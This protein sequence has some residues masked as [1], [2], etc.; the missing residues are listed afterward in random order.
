MQHTMTLLTRALE[1]RP[2]PEWTRELG[3]SRNALANAKLRG[4]VSPAIAGAIAEKLGEDPIRWTAIAALES[5]KDSA[6]KSRMM[7]VAR[8]WSPAHTIH[9]A[10]KYWHLWAATL[11]GYQPLCGGAVAIK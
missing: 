3:L 9:I 5:E 10:A 7:R 2:A 6:C 8:T 4:H 11:A 1:T